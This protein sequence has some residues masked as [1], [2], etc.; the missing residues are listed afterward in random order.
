L[1]IIESERN[2]KELDKDDK[3]YEENCNLYKCADLLYNSVLDKLESEYNFK[4]IEAD[5]S[6]GLFEYD[7]FN[8]QDAKIT[9]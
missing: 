6:F 8:L 3:N 2:L 7:K 5:Y 9:G 1:Y 4:T